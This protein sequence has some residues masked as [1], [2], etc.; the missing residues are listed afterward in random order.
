MHSEIFTLRE[1]KGVMTR[2]HK[3][4]VDVLFLNLQFSKCK[5]TLPLNGEGNKKI[6]MHYQPREMAGTNHWKPCILYANFVYQRVG[7]KYQQLFCK[8]ISKNYPF[9]AV[10]PFN[11]STFFA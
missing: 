10:Q 5:A 7:T 3:T 6:R 4:V 11:A 2:F 9:E 8:C 1:N